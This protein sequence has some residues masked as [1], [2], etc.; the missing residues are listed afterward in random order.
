LV[1]KSASPPASVRGQ[2]KED[3]WEPKELAKHLEE[4][5]RG[6][7]RP[8]SMQPPKSHRLRADG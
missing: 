7:K 4:A 5:M 6:E 8:S 2:A 3:G 1:L